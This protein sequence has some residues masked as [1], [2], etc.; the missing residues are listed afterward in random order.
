MPE[1]RNI[2]GVAVGGS[3][4]SR[5]A[6]CHLS[7]CVTLSATQKNNSVVLGQKKSE[8]IEKNIRIFRFAKFG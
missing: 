2:P 3:T 6:L 5:H 8:K 7:L 1:N 4:K